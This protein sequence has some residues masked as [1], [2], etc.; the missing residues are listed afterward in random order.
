MP[1]N[2]KGWLSI[3]DLSNFFFSAYFSS[4]NAVLP[5]VACA[6]FYSSLSDSPMLIMSSSSGEFYGAFKSTG[7]D[8][9]S[10][11]SMSSA[12]IEWITESILSQ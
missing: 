7:W 3:L 12:H 5:M 9:N 1:V 6:A 11:E 10:Y 4:K 8:A 2:W